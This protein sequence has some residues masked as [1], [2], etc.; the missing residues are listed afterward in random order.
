MLSGRGCI[1]T[2]R[3]PGSYLHDLHVTSTHGP[4]GGT[5]VGHL[6]SSSPARVFCVL[7]DLRL[8]PVQLPRKK[9]VLQWPGQV[10]ICASSIFW[11]TEV[12]EAIVNNTLPVSLRCHASALAVA[13]S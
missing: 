5:S 1:S 3:Y 13:P 2:P 10:V 4:G 11:T 9:W 7:S 8:H 6:L 12:S